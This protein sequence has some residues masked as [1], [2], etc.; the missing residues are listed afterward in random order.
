MSTLI[1]SGTVSDSLLNTQKAAVPTLTGSEGIN[2]NLIVR[3]TTN[4]VKGTVLF[5]ENTP[6]YGLN[7]GAVQLT[8]GLSANHNLTTGGV[9]LHSPY[10]Q[11]VNNVVL[12]QQ[13]SYG[14]QTTITT[15]GQTYTFPAFPTV[16]FSNPQLPGGQVA[17]G[18]AVIQSNVVVQ[19][20]ITDPGTGYT[21]P[22]QVTF[23]DP[24]PSTNTVSTFAV[25]GQT[26]VV[27]AFIKAPQTGGAIF[28]YIVTTSAV[29]TSLPTFSSGS[30]SAAGPTMTFIGAL[31]QGYASA[32]YTGAQIQGAVQSV[33]CLTQVVLTAA[34][35]SYAQAP[36]IT[37]SRPDLPGGRQPT[38]IAQLS[39]G[40]L[41]KID[42]IDP[43]TGYIYPPTVTITAL[44]GGG[45]GATANAVIGAPATRSV[46]SML[47][48]Q[49]FTSGA[50]TSYAPAAQ[51]GTFANT[52]YLD[53]SHQG[54]DIAFIQ[55]TTT[56]NIYF[57]S[58]NNTTSG[59]LLKNGYTQGRKVTLYFKNSAAPSVT[60]NFP[61]LQG[62]NSSSGSNSFSIGGN[63]TGRFEFMVI[64]NTNTQT[65]ASP[66]LSIDVYCTAVIA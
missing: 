42:I 64:H 8:G 2:Q 40:A 62:V 9:L 60:V 49:A 66:P 20:V 23:S 41:T 48:G 3:S 11:T 44:Q 46:V 14:T 31:A 1:A 33:G 52:Y 57:D 30:S 15:G 27:G 24:T 29:F 61:N 50:L 47:T 37:F 25:V 13:G 5:D 34:G 4:A 10:G 63:R 58:I 45:S 32:G 7:N 19:V 21:V 22:P 26:P 18:Y 38:A 39:G 54:N 43:G 55:S 35:S 59:F 28:Y 6:S 16:T 36:A 53:F 12:Y 65:A 51:A 56:T 17:K